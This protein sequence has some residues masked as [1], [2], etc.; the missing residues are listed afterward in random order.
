VLTLTV[1]PS[2]LT[3]QKHTLLTNKNKIAVGRM[4]G[5]ESHGWVVVRGSKVQS[6]SMAQLEVLAI[7]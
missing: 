6:G 2:S 4:I 1:F 5:E 7:S 3:Q